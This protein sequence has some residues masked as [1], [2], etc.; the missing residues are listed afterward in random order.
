MNDTDI[1][2]KISDKIHEH[3]IR[4]SNLT[5]KTTH[6]QLGDADVKLLYFNEKD[7]GVPNP[8]KSFISVTQRKI[9]P[10]E[11]ISAFGS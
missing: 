4:T 8:A 2:V 1:I 3:R 7:L 10:S 11:F 5:P 9:A 6:T